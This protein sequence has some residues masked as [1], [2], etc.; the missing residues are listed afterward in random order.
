MRVSP[1]KNWR[2]DKTNIISVNE[3]SGKTDLTRNA[4]GQFHKRCEHEALY[5]VVCDLLWRA[6]DST[7]KCSL[8]F[9]THSPTHSLTH[10]LNHSL[11]NLVVYL[12]YLSITSVRLERADVSYGCLQDPVGYAMLCLDLLHLLHLQCL[13]VRITCINVVRPWIMT[14]WFVL[15]V[16]SEDTEHIELL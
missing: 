10:P 1:E 14:M 12:F 3:D 4:S 16:F 13:S 11:I 2:R 9:L 8:M 7:N 15:P 6:A 5:F